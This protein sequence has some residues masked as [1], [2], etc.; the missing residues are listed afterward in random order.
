VLFGS[1]RLV[2]KELVLPSLQD[3]ANIP[4]VILTWQYQLGYFSEF[5]RW[6]TLPVNGGPGGWCCVPRDKGVIML[7][8]I[9]PVTVLGKPRMDD[10]KD[11]RFAARL[12]ELR[13]AVG[14][15]QQ[16]LGDRAGLHKLTV[17]KLEQGL[18]EPSWATVQALAAALGVDCRAFQEESAPRQ[19]MGP[20]RP[21]KPNSE[22][23]AEQPKRPRGRPRK[24]QGEREAGG[25]KKPKGTRK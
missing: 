20:G 18:R 16:Q 17:A 21:A 1:E 12:K 11:T 22:Q 10:A 9:C 2:V 25:G 5:F 7:P 6:R 24:D 14:L 8:A 13:E 19:R 23:D 15:T 4:T 3:D